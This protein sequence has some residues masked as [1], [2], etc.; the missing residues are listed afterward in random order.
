MNKIIWWDKALESWLKLK[1]E[2]IKVSQLG[3]TGFSRSFLIHERMKLTA[4][5]GQEAYRWIIKNGSEELRLR[6]LVE[7]IQ[8]LDSKIKHMDDKV[9]G[10]THHLS[11]NL[12][13][14]EGN[15]IPSKRKFAKRKSKH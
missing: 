4:Q 12:N 10:I 1:D 9:S 6:K 7:Q 2:V 11:Q 3:R 14:E 8:K 15:D 13:A 5:L